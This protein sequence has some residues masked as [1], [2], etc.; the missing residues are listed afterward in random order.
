M[1]PRPPLRIALTGDSILM[2][3]LGS[4][5]DA[6]VRPLFDIVR[7]ADVAFTNLE[8]LPN[9]YR[10]DPALESG[11]SHFAA[12]PWVIDELVDAGFDLFA[13]ATNHCLDYS[14][15]GLLAAKEELD[16]RGVLYA[17]IG[18]HLGEARMPAYREHPHGTVAMLSCAST[19]A[20][21]QEAA[22]QSAEM[23][24]RP[25]LNPLRF[26]T[27]HQVTPAQLGALREVAEQLGLEKQRQSKIQLGFG[28]PL[29]NPEAV[30]LGDLVF[31]AADEV[32][33]RTKA[34]AKD[35]DAIARWVR[36]ARLVSDVVMVSVHAHEQGASKEDPAEFLVAFARQMIDEGADMVVGHGPHLLRGMEI[37]R[38]KPIFYSLGNFIG[39]NELVARLP[40]DSFERFR[41]DPALT[42]AAVYRQRTDDDRKGFPSDRRFWETVMPVCTY[43]EGRLS[44]IEIHPVTLGLGE[45]RHLRGRPR[46]AEGEEA[47]SI[48]RRF[49]ALSAPFGVTMEI[50]E[51]K[52]RVA[53]A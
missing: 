50:A 19:F 40:M 36:E 35:L 2:R 20:K 13:A 53:L 46:L 52:A 22:L 41:A 25:G 7:D 14:I 43:A 3:R 45:A 9:G 48:L 30:A 34:K 42:P 8:C 12:P 24:G 4:L 21:G 6:Q 16:R 29:E 39:Q 5:T 28:F 11:G 27:V 17:G 49:A 26:D 32:A 44:G 23:Q 38:G 18:Q 31:S 51:G 15:S 47:Q 33:L 1:T 37:Y 10:G